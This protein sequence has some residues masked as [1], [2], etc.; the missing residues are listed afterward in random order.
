MSRLSP[1]EF[2]SVVQSRR[3]ARMDKIDAMS[4]EMRALVNEYGFRVVDT[5]IRLGITKPRHIRHLVETV[6]DEF[7]PSRGSPSAQG[8]R[9]R[10]D[11]D[12]KSCG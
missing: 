9:E 12:T 4:A 11:L 10:F 5:H 1:D 6:L 3:M 2:Q 8:R 7:S